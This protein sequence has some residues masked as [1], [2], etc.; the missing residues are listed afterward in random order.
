MVE[1]VSLCTLTQIMSQ[2]SWLSLIPCQGF[3]LWRARL[4]YIYLFIPVIRSRFVSSSALCWCAAF[5]T[6]LLLFWSLTVQRHISRPPG[7]DPLS[8]FYIHTN[9]LSAFSFFYSAEIS[10][11]SSLPRLNVA[12][13]LNKSC[14]VKLLG[15]VRCCACTLCG[16]K[17]KKSWSRFLLFS[18]VFSTCALPRR[19]LI[20]HD[21]KPVWNL[22]SHVYY[23][24]NVHLDLDRFDHS[25]LVAH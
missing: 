9:P 7:S 22:N 15:H 16:V 25:S 11:C 21:H 2:S 13:F 17:K 8:L 23:C 5:F 6:P 24:I 12:V 20:M 4:L 19:R 14:P 18:G 10:G 3:S 1:R